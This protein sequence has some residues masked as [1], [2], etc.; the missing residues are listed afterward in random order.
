MNLTSL[1]GARSPR[2]RGLI[3]VG[4]IVIAVA[5]YLALS[6]SDTV[7]GAM[8]SSAA[9]KQQYADGLKRKQ[10]LEREIAVL[11]PKVDTATYKDTSEKVIPIV[12]KSLHEQ[13]R[14]A[15]IRLRE[16]KPLRPRQTGGVTKVTLTVRFTTA[17]AKAIPF[18]YNLEDPKA[19]LVVEKMNVSPSD[20]KSRDVDV[21]VQVALFTV[22]GSEPK[23][24]G[25]KT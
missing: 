4:V 21:E 15:D 7:G 11:R 18:L 1:W 5:V 2:E 25:G 3:V 16:V 10:E 12:L 22:E 14:L 24:G 9:A 19:R 20:P 23:A 17:F 6:P 13:A 8:L